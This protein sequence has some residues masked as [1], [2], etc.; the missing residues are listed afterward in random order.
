MHSFD[1]DDLLVRL[2]DQLRSAAQILDARQLL[3]FS[4]GRSAHTLFGLPAQDLL[5]PPV[6]YG[7]SSF[8]LL[9]SV[10]ASFDP[11]TL[12]STLRR[13]TFL[14]A[15]PVQAPAPEGIRHYIPFIR[16]RP[17][18]S[19]RTE[20][21]IEMDGGGNGSVRIATLSAALTDGCRSSPWSFSRSSSWPASRPASGTSAPPRQTPLPRESTN[22]RKPS[23]P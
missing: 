16:P 22:R 21:C 3:A 12:S 10:I 13:F 8:Q 7:I 2:R 15:E 11:A 4:A 18:L 6:R 5:S 19:P 17:P 9:F 14:L 20:L 1:L 23:I